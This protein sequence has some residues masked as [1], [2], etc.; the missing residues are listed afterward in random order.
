MFYPGEA[1]THS[2]PH[3]KPEAKCNEAEGGPLGGKVQPSVHSP[4]ASQIHFSH[5]HL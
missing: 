1:V 4:V 3:T 2:P 5:L